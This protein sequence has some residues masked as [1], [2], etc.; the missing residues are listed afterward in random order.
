[1]RLTAGLFD[2]VSSKSNMISA[3]ESHCGIG[4]LVSPIGG[5]GVPRIG[6]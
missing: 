6:H 1:V 5:A 4:A 3:A 2:P